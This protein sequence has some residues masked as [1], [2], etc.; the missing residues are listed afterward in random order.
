[1][2]IS[3]GIIFIHL[4]LL[5][6]YK[7]VAQDGDFSLDVGSNS[8]SKQSDSSALDDFGS[9]VNLFGDEPIGS[10]NVESNPAKA[11]AKA[12]G[13]GGKKEGNSIQKSFSFSTSDKQQQWN[14]QN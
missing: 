5:Y 13:L 2:R 3:V 12:L 14:N 6:P 7:A 1:M 10:E 11:G 4:S 9:T 8:A